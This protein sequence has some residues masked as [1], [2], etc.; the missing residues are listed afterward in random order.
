[1]KFKCNTDS[2][3]T[4]LYFPEHNLA[5]ECNKSRQTLSTKLSA[6]Y[7]SKLNWHANLS[8]IIQMWKGSTSLTRS[9]ESCWVF[10]GVV[11]FT[12]A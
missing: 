8:I 4:D 9:T 1:M 7:V 11:K 10:E 2:C 6:K 3:R 5:I 12:Q